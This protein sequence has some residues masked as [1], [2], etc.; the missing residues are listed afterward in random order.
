MSI[1]QL[2]IKYQKYVDNL[3]WHINTNKPTGD[4]LERI[5][6]RLLDFKEILIDLKSIKPQ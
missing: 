2:K 4:D 5:N 1:D 6:Q 3:E